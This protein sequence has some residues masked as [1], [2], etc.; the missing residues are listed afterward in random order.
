MKIK[1]LL[2]LVLGCQAAYPQ[3]LYTTTRSYFRQDPFKTEFS[4]FLP[5]LMNDPGL[6]EKKISKKTD[7]TLFY[8][9]GRYNSYYPFTI[10]TTHCKIILAEMQNYPDSS[11]KE[12]FTYFVYQLIG[13][14]LPGESGLNDIRQEYEKLHRRFK[15]EMEVNVLKELE[16]EGVQSGAIMNYTFKGMIFY[17]LTVAWA[18]SAAMAR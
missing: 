15:K 6:I 1:F 13:Y 10:T 18:S 17:P 12:P 3:W 4:L 5:S 7:S 2:I 16:R 14:A 9:E 11:N 8:L